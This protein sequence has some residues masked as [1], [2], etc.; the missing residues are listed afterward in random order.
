MSSVFVV[1]VIAII[2]MG[3]TVLVELSIKRPGTLTQS[4]SGTSASSFSTQKSTI[5]SSAG[6]LSLPGMGNSSF[7]AGLN[8]DSAFHWYSAQFTN[9]SVLRRDFSRFH[10]DGIN[11]VELG[12][13]WYRLEGDTQGDYNGTRSALGDYGDIF[14]GHVKHV[15]SIARDYGLKVLVDIH[16]VWGVDGIWA[17]PKYVADPVTGNSDTLAI[18]RSPAMRE[19]FPNMFTHTVR[20]LAGTPGI[21]AWAL[22]NEPWYYPHQ[23]P[24]PFEGID[25]EGNFATLIQ[26]MSSMVRENDGRPVTVK[27]GSVNA[28]NDTAGEPQVGNIF[29]DDWHWDRRVLGSLDFLSFDTY[30][31]PYPQLVQKWENITAGDVLGSAQKGKPVI[32]TEFGYT[33]ND[34]NLQEANFRTMVD[35]FKSLPLDGWTAWEWRCDWVSDNVPIGEGYNRCASAGGT[36]RPAYY[37]IMNHP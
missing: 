2:V 36:P 1:L 28:F 6:T 7:L 25:Q 31:P 5:S 9:D 4:S 18:V 19:A 11:L 12:L 22:L 17:T 15:I 34:N 13:Y 27:F 29:V 23:L 8:Y 32:I 35:L 37:E 16:T 14:L 24:P 30:I 21:W 20:Y 3:V 26:N 10:Q 33:S